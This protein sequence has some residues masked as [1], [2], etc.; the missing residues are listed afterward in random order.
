[1]EAWG[2]GAAGGKVRKLALADFYSLFGAKRDDFTGVQARTIGKGEKFAVSLLGPAETETVAVSVLK[3]IN[4]P[5]LTVAGDSGSNRRWEKGWA[6]N[7]QDFDPKMGFESLRP[8]YV[9]SGQPVRLFQNYV[10][11]KNPDFEYEWYKIFLEYLARKYMGGSDTIYEF[12]CG[13]G[14]NVAFLSQFFKNKK[15]IWGL[16]WAQSS[17]R[18]VEA[19]ARAGYNVEGRTFN[20]FEPDE[21][22]KLAEGSTVLTV[23]AMEQ[24]GPRYL[25]FIDYLLKQRVALCVNIEPIVEWYDQSKLVDYLAVLFHER[26]KYWS[27]FPAL[28]DG[29]Q[30][31]GKVNIVKQKRSFFGS[32]YIEGYSQNIWKPLR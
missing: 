22:F 24:T 12:G 32:L 25:R 8:K 15:R 4:S 7:L 23:G 31:K 19:M 13:S 14:I 18:I 3:R 17:V 1:M 11:P 28:L 30:R 5:D 16:D 27:G 21:S 26:R 6:E 2:K 9:R 10:I 29:L 20:F